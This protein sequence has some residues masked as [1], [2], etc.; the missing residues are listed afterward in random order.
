MSLLLTAPPAVEPVVLS[1]VK[2]HLR[3]T[4]T[5]DDIYISTLIVSAR[6]RV[7]AATGLKLIT[8]GWSQFLN[9]WPDGGMVDL[10]LKPVSAINDVVIFGDTDAPA[11]ID[12]AH[13]FLD[14]TS[15]PARLI[16]RQGRNPAPPG[17]RA[18][19]IEIRVI[20]G[21]GVA[22]S[23][24]QELKQAILVLVADQFAH[25][26]DDAA[27]VMPPDV[28]DLLNPYRVMRLT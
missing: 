19:G 20:A 14:A 27:R 8:Q 22:V 13:Y 12:P 4:H 11:T 10:E 25:R 9:C 3:V 6:R 23:V 17:R 26:G 1:E 28:L 24:P 7:E 21:F 15:N 18:K 16:F 5:D 2:A